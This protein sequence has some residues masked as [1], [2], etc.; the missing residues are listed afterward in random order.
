M[1]ILLC[2]SL[3]QCIDTNS[4]K[5]TKHGACMKKVQTVH[6]ATLLNTISMFT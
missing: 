5:N 2:V 4:L 1:E 6:Q 3:S